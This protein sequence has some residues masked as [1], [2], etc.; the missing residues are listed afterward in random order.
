[1]GWEGAE[2]NGVTSRLG[3]NGQQNGLRSERL[4]GAGGPSRRRQKAAGLAG[5]QAGLERRPVILE[6]AQ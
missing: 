3:R 4:A 5:F 2:G 6:P 1:M